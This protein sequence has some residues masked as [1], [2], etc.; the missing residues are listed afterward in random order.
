[1]AKIIRVGKSL[2]PAPDVHDPRLQGPDWRQANP[3][4]IAQALEHA[5]SQPDGGWYVLDAASAITETPRA[6]TV[7]DRALVA[8]RGPSGELQVAPEACPHM[9]ASLNCAKTREGRLVCPWHGLELGSEG[10][11]RWRLFES[12]DDG[13]LAWVQLDVGAPLTAAPILTPRPTR[14]MDAVIR[15]EARCD[16]EDV[17]A[18]RLDPWH[19][20]HFHAASFAALRVLEAND[21]CLTLRVSKRLLGPICIE[22]D[23][24]FHCPTSRSIVM[25]IIAGEGVGSVVETH[26][27]PIRGGQTAIIEATLASS[28]RRGFQHARMFTRWIRPFIRRAAY[29]LWE[30]DLVYAERL[31][32]LRESDE[33]AEPLEVD[34]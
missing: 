27:T 11:G 26:A 29:K 24:T 16:P 25:T 31:L 14:P 32:E 20:A 33:A 6:Y 5:C 1:M 21:R 28:D 8:W 22:V 4:L 2:P 18:N 19:G 7:L 13:V 15:M 34:Q 17:I 3:R 23:A 12:H 30:D 10:H 9:G